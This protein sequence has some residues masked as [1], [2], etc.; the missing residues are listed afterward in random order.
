METQLF[1][2]TIIYLSIFLLPQMFYSGLKVT[3][4][5]VYQSLLIYYITVW[6]NAAKSYIIQVEIAQRRVIKQCF[7]KPRTV[8]AVFL[9]EEWFIE[10][11]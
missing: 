8:P 11:S 4:F 2:I 7:K 6:G 9:H 5:A 10:C 1:T 3:S